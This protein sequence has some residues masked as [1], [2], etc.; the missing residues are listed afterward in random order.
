MEKFGVSAV[1]IEDKK[2]P[3]KNS[4]DR[5]AKH[6]LEDAEI[7]ANKIKVGK[8]VS[9]NLLIIARLE[10]LIATNCSQDELLFRTEAYLKAGADGIMIHSKKDNPAEV[11]E[12]AKNYHKHF[13]GLLVAAPTTYN[14]SHEQIIDYHFG[15]IIY[16]NHLFRASLR[17]MRDT[18][19]LMEK[20]AAINVASIDDIFN[21]TDYDN[22][23]P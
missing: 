15:I 3:K 11:F 6:I 5:G 9:K 8:D 14:L 7:F 20:G 19:E 4:F 17:A 10:G 16:A 13:G 22:R 2:F 21:V 12:F 18:I 23:R 1:I